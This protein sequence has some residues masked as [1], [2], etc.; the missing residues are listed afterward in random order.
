MKLINNT[1]K[2]AHRLLETTFIR[3]CIVG[4]ISTVVDLSILYSLT[5]F[6]GIHYLKS[7]TI[8]FVIGAIINF[9]LNKKYSYRNTSK[10]VHKQ[11]PIFLVVATTGL[12]INLGLLYLFVT[13]LAIWYMAAK[14]LAILIIMF[15][16]FFINKFVTFNTK[17]IQ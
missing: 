16:N 9:S 1:F 11:F 2:L 8:S 14:I 6:A 4:A 13:H 12:A 3:F 17:F 5:E 15:W 10:Q 7:A